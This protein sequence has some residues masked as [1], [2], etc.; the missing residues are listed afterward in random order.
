MS[1]TITYTYTISK[2][3]LDVRFANKVV[4]I[5]FTPYVKKEE[6]IS[7][8]GES[9]TLVQKIKN[10]YQNIYQKELKIRNASFIAEIW[11]HLAAYKVALWIKKN[12]K[13]WPV[14]KF[15]KFV[16]FRSGIID[17]GEGSIDTN[18]WVWDILAWLF[19]K[20]HK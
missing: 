19:F 10:K 13:V 6:L 17:C 11:G 1:K 14:Q 7:L 15:A 20:K 5:D 16:A 2:L 18:R 8:Y 4:S 9:Q 3:P 12:I